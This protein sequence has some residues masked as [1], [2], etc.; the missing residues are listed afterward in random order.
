MLKQNTK[1]HMLKQNTK[2]HN[3]YKDNEK[4]FLKL[5]S[6]QPKLTRKVV[7][8]IKLLQAVWKLKIWVGMQSFQHHLP[9]SRVCWA[10]SSINEF[11]NEL[12]LEIF[13]DLQIT[14]SVICFKIDPLKFNPIHTLLSLSHTHT[15]AWHKFFL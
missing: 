15:H 2:N 6:H 11:Y 8:N 1:N 7:K 9:N 12:K 3:K 5:K 13:I 4:K 14:R 10:L